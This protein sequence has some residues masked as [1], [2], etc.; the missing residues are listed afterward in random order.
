MALQQ[1]KENRTVIAN[2]LQD[3]I[4]KCTKERMKSSS[5]WKV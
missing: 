1:E 2:C 5:R 4:A 3:A